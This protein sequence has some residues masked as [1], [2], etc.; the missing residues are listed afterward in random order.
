MLAGAKLLVEALIDRRISES[1]LSDAQSQLTQGSQSGH[2][3]V[4]GRLYEGGVDAATTRPLFPDLDAYYETLQMAEQA[5][6]D[7]GDE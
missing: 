1:Q 6:A 4:L 5:L 3:E 7:G 2:R